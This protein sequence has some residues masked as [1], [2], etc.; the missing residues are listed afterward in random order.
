MEADKT[1]LNILVSPKYDADGYKEVPINIHG[2]QYLVNI[3][4]QNVKTCI[5]AQNKIR[6]R[7]E[8]TSPQPEEF[9]PQGNRDYINILNTGSQD[10]HEI[11]ITVRGNIYVV[12]VPRDTVDMV[13]CRNLIGKKIRYRLDHAP[14]QKGPHIHCSIEDNRVRAYHS[15]TQIGCKA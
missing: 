6:Y 7:V 12:R 10:C 11:T 2:R 1:F 8:H 13:Y 5:S 3:P 15:K 4:L 9:Q 14:S